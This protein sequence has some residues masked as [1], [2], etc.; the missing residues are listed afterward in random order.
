MKNIIHFSQDFRLGKPQL[1]GYS[2]IINQLSDGNKHN[3]FTIGLMDDEYQIKVNNGLEVKVIQIG[4]QTLNYY[5]LY[6]QPILIFQITNKIK[7]KIQEGDIKPDFLFGHSQLF[8]SYILAL[9]KYRHYKYAKIIWEF[10]VIWGFDKINDRKGRFRSLLQRLSQR[11]VIGFSDG[12]VFQTESCREFIFKKYNLTNKKNIVIL[13][14]ISYNKGIKT[15]KNKQA[16][17]IYGLLD[18]LNGIKFLLDFVEKQK[19]LIPFEFHFYGNGNYAQKIEDFTNRFKKIK[20]FGSVNKKDIPD[21]LQTYQF[22]IIPRIETLGSN[23]Y[24]PTKVIELMNFGVIVLASDVKGLTEVIEDGFNGII[25]KNGVDDDFYLKLNSL[26]DMPEEKINIFVSNARL[27]IQN[28]FD[29]NYQ[30]KNQN[31]FFNS[32]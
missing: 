30:L 31:S 14:S 5:S 9:L 12:L 15:R 29:L 10:N 7:K 2:R 4:V 19:G 13:N 32:F 8:N 23:L 11:F 26:I 16:I 17:L 21:L 24:I 25:F 18:E 6:K 28:K 3:I 20:Y 22:S 27:T 1:G